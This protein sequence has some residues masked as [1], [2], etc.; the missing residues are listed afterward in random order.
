MPKIASNTMSW[1]RIEVSS[2]FEARLNRTVPSQVE[3]PPRM[4]LQ[5]AIA[6]SSPGSMATGL[7][8]RPNVQPM[9][10]ETIATPSDAIPT[11]EL[12]SFPETSSVD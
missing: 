5:N 7:R 10:N 11:I 6:P 3:P 12:Q 8:A 9:G 4:R 2:F 1:P